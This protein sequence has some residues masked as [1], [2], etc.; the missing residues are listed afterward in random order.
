MAKK[1]PTAVV[2]PQKIDSIANIAA[3][4]K[5]ELVKNPKEVLNAIEMDFNIAKDK[6]QKDVTLGQL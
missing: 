4:L 3:D 6:K 1:K 2:K 5:K